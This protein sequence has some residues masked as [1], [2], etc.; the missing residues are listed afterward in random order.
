MQACCFF[1]IGNLLA[2]VRVL[3]VSFLHLTLP[4]AL[5]VAQM[6]LVGGAR[7]AEFYVD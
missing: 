4:A 2:G 5:R 3:F 1:D 7:E 6:G